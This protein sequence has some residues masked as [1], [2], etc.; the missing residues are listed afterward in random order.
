MPIRIAD[1]PEL[2]QICWNMREDMV[3]DAAEALALYEQTGT[4]WIILLLRPMSVT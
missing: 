4:S 1:Y 3:V 2:W